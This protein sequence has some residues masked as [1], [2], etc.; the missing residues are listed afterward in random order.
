[1][2]IIYLL[3]TAHG[4]GGT[5][6]T[7]FN[8]A[9]AMVERGHE[10]DLVTMWRDQDD[11]PFHLDDRV[12]L[13][14]LVDGRA[15]AR[16]AREATHLDDTSWHSHFPEKMSAT[17]DGRLRVNAL[18]EYLR[19]LK[20]GIVVST[21]PTLSLVVE[22][23][24]DPSLVR[25]V[26][27]H[28]HLGFHNPEWR[29]AIDAAYPSF[30]AL[31]T[32]TEEDQRSYT[33]AFPGVPRIDRIPNPLS[34]LDGPVSDLTGKVVVS[35]GRLDPA[36]GFDHL[37]KA[38]GM[39]VE[40]HPDWTLRIYGGG[41]Q[42][43]RL[44]RMILDGHLYNHVYL[45]GFTD[46]LSEMLA[47]GSIFGMSSRSEGFGMVLLE[48]MNCGLPPVSFDCPVGPREIITSG[49]DGMLVPL[50]DTAAL[51]EGIC[52][53]IEDE[54][55]RREYGEAARK[56]AARYDPDVIAEAWERLFAELLAEKH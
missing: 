56:T 32:L 22:R 11:L 26:Q 40:R 4:V 12:R 16:E 15:S 45:M 47:K 44:R 51:A 17:A 18:A 27:E 28:A 13:I 41:P 9:N 33:E 36:K 31:V 6:R 19:G 5:V 29:A 54:D 20:D 7:V 23:F 10:V 53:L 49:R 1:M 25:I 39:V 50:G 52:R 2:R 30:D 48:A 24:T 38:F 35:A 3:F 14:P 55:L 37:I 8:Q 46:R 42:E 34:S 43:A 21:R